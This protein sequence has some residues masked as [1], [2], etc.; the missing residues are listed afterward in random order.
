MSIAL[1]ELTN[2]TPADANP[3]MENFRALRTAVE[4]AVSPSAVGDLKLS[5]ATS[6]PAGWFACEGQ[7][8]SRVTFKALFEAIGV[9]YG[10]GDKATTFNIPDYR[11]RSPL[12]AGTGAGLTARALGT[13]LG[14]ETHV[15]EASEMPS[16]GHA[17]TDPGHTHPGTGGNS[18]MQ[19]SG[20]EHFK[21]E[22]SGFG[23]GGVA[24][25]GSAVTG[26]TVGNTGGGAAHNTM[27]PSTVCNV[28]IKS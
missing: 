24:A 13:K 28:W 26:V 7:A 15:L 8:V 18:F 27:H 6:V 10:E 5:A 3:V 11:G 4:E 1:K 25:T 17:V 23:I 21:V 2:G 9:A 12:G 22:G 16:H 20:P 19:S 14:Q